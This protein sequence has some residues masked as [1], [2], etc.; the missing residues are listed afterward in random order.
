VKGA[1]DAVVGAVK[2]GVAALKAWWQERRQFAGVDGQSHSLY[3]EGSGAGAQLIVA[4]K[5]TE[6]V[7]FLRELIEV[8]DSDQTLKQKASEALDFYRRKIV[9]VKN[10]APQ[11]EAIEQFGNDLTTLSNMLKHLVGVTYSGIPANAEWNWS[12]PVGHK[13][14]G[15]ELLSTRSSGGGTP[16]T[17]DPKG[18][19]Q[20]QEAGLTRLRGD[21]K[22]MHMITAAVGGL[23]IARN[24]IPAPTS[25]NSGPKVRGFE[26][27]LEELVKRVDGQTRKPNVVWAQA[28]TTG[29]HPADEDVPYDETTFA[30]GIEFK[31]GLHF[32][33]E[34]SKWVRNSRAELT[35]SDTIPPPDFAGGPIDINSIRRTYLVK[36]LKVSDRFAM[37]ILAVRGDDPFTS[38]TSFDRRMRDSRTA[39]N[40]PLTDEFKVSISLVQA[41]YNDNKIRFGRRV[42]NP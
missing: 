12:D 38:F 9:T 8:P 24:L 33:D 4:S 32:P 37:E 7:A 40:M 20:L 31:A 29:F 1:L 42:R 34:N 18:W 36:T 26:L 25:V 35:A 22:Q 5:P 15:V 6:L 11:N 10:Q 39:Q 13:S 3:F 41:A 19:E 27:R 28:A 23:G 14:V 21:W 16:P 17:Q 30:S 2:S